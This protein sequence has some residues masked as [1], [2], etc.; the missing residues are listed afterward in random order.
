MTKRSDR[1]A[2]DDF[3]RQAEQARQCAAWQHEDELRRDDLAPSR[4]ILVALGLSVAIWLTIW[5]VW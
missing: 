2:H 4:G 5:W 1:Q 3:E